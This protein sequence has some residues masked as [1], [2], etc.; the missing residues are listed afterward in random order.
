MQG[1]RR[2]SLGQPVAAWA[3]PDRGGTGSAFVTVH[4]T[5]PHMGGLDRIHARLERE[6]LALDH[7]GAEDLLRAEPFALLLGVLLDQQVRAEQAFE[8]PARFLERF[9]SLHPA[10]IAG[11]DEGVLY[12]VF[13]APP[14]LHRFPRKM[15]DAARSLA[16][17]VAEDLEG[18]A[19]ALWAGAPDAETVRRRAGDLP[20]FGASKAG[21][22]VHALEV[23]G[24][25]D[26]A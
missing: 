1:W 15:A 19:G 12:E 18:H 14:A 23:F 20:G 13:A 3:G 4:Q 22:L 24:Y 17:Y 6:G 5:H 9:G 7:P 10:D 11:A 8:A 26:P 25:R 16:A 2:R 21:T